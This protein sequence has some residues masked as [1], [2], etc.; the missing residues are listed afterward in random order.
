MYIAQS[1]IIAGTL[2]AFVRRKSPILQLQVIGWAVGVIAIWWRYGEGQLGFYSN[3]QIHYASIVR[4]LVYETWPRT[5]AW[6]L[7]FS[8]IPYPAAAVPLTIAGIHAT[9]ALKTVSLLCLLI[10]SAQIID[11][12]EASTFTHQFKAV[13]LAGCG[14]I[15]GLFST[16]ALRETMMMLLVY[17]YTFG[18]SI[19]GRATVLILL[20]L[21]RSHLALAIVAAELALATWCWLTARVRTGYFEFPAL[22]LIGVTIGTILFTWRFAGLKRI[23]TP[24]SGYWG[25]RDVLQVA[26]NYVGL[27]FLTSHEAFV[28]LSISELLLLRVV[29]NDTILIPFA[30]TIACLLLGPRLQQS[31]RFAL[32]TF[33]IYVSIVT[34]T[35]FNSF[36]QNIP[37]MPLLGV[38]ILDAL[39]D[40]KKRLSQRL[41]VDLPLN[42][43]IRR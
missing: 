25:I 43:T 15:G 21:L 7:D 37:L 17:K 11:R 3:D 22:T 2:Y 14:L 40:R 42:S 9:L 32:L 10:L 29:F 4:I 8:K 23:Q 20:F 16:L 19:A 6:W 31:H 39:Q 36:R 13:Y 18:R 34:S 33:T 38:V 27:Q 26:S 30:F 24:F 28:K 35:D 5:I 41:N 1:L 12:Y